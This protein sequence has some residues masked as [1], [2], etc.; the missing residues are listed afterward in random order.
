MAADK[1]YNNRR[2]RGQLKR[3]RTLAVIPPSGREK[4]PQ[5]NFDKTLYKALTEQNDW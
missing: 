2:T 3:K 4:K 5:K 1:A